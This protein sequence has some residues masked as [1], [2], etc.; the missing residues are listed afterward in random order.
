MRRFMGDKAYK[1]RQLRYRRAALAFI[2]HERLDDELYNIAS[3]CNDLE[4]A[5]ADD[6]TLL[7]V[8]DGDADEIH[9]F[10]M[11]FSD[12]SNN[13]ERLLRQL[14]NEYVTEHFDDFFVGTL[15]SAYNIVGYDSFEEDYF[16]LTRYEAEL[17]QS[18]S[19]KR[20]M[21]LT[22]EKII[23]TA[24]QCVGI[25]MCF[26]DIRHSYDCLKAVF[27]MLRDDRAELLKNVRSVEEAYQKTQDNPY[28]YDARA[29]YESLL[30][31][32][33]DRVWVE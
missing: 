9:E 3:E 2:Q 11:Q 24:G 5:V 30:S 14:R 12:L 32:L 16:N 27:D 13:C 21:G 33:P 6:E 26:L 7:D 31:R 28:D 25:M 23:A 22:K 1:A 17:A 8:F 29:E 18:V 20:L 4:W 10:R 15:G 19:G